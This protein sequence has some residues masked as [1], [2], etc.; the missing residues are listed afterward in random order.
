MPRLRQ[1]VTWPSGDRDR[2]RLLNCILGDVDVPKATDQRCDRAAELLTENPADVGL[3]EL[4]LGIG[5]AHRGYAPRICKNGRTS[6]GIP[7]QSEVFEAHESASSRSAELM[8]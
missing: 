5:P 2:E 6:I 3:V 8:M 1:A 4:Y 7:T